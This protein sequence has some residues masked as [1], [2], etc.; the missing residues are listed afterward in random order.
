MLYTFTLSFH[1]IHRNQF[2]AQYH[3]INKSVPIAM[4]KAQKCSGLKTLLCELSSDEEHDTD[5]SVMPSSSED[6]EKL[7]KREYNAYMDTIHDVPE[8]MSAIQ[9]WGVCAF[10]FYYPSAAYVAFSII[11]I[12]CQFGHRLLETTFQSWLHQFRVSEHSRKVG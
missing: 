11:A 12:D 2:E 1:Q 7:W 10:H 3:E 9:W 8:G 4:R 5:S 6:P